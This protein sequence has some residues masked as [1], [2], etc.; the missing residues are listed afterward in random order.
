MFTTFNAAE[1]AVHYPDDRRLVAR[2]RLGALAVGAALVLGPGA[3]AWAQYLALG[4]PADPSALLLA[5]AATDPQGFPAWLRLGH[6]VNFFFL[7][8]IVRSGLSIL[9]DHARLYWNNGCAPG[10]DWLRFTPVAVPT[11]RVWTAKEDARYLSPVLGLP[12]YR[13]TVGLARHWH[14]IT[15]PFFLLN[16]AVFIALLFFTN[17][18]QR[19]VPTSWQVLPDAW[20]IFVYYA[21][22]HLPVEPN[23]FFHYNALQQLSYFVVV[24]VLAP[25]SMLSGMA[26]S[27]AIENRFHWFPKLF[28]NRQGARSV[29][30]LVTVA[31]VAFTI[32]HV[33]MVAATGLTRNMNHM[34][35]GRDDA[36]SHTGLWIGAGVLLLTVAA[37]VG[38]QWVS[39]QRPRALQQTAAAINGNLWRLSIDQF[40]PTVY[41]KKTDITPYF[42]LNGKLP[43]S[44]RAGEQ[45]PG[46]RDFGHVEVGVRQRNPD[47]RR[48]F[49]FSRSAKLRFGGLRR[50][51]SARRS[52]SASTALSR[53][54]SVASV[55]SF[56]VT[57][58]RALMP[59]MRRSCRYSEAMA[60]A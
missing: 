56:L 17:Q 12:G 53:R 8:L 26:M 44:A 39:W 2:F 13:H 31:Y 3:L 24:F 25:V 21:T 20:R 33:A 48:H 46:H 14:F 28:G 36:V 41:Y 5:P 4:L 19:L 16:G 37:A 38:A 58:E 9:A 1:R 10:T 47:L 18:W 27:P 51:S 45:L 6:W 32:I 11:D 34:G 55:A 40:K 59:S 50:S 42:W 57:T 35:T 52:R 54:R 22:F 23:G 43:D 7:V 60:K 29:H 15:V 49:F 30:F